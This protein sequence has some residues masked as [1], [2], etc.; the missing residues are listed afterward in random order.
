MWY[1]HLTERLMK[2]I[3]MKKLVSS[4]NKHYR[5]GFVDNL[6]RS[7]MVVVHIVIIIRRFSV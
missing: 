7:W 5:H 2:S 3:Q 6:W 1:S 4:Y